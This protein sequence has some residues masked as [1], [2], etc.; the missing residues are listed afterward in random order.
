MSKATPDAIVSAF[1]RVAARAPSAPL[2]V[3]PGQSPVAVGA[4]DALARAAESTLG[5]LPSTDRV[6]GLAV[7]NGPA[8][9][10][11]FLAL[12][13]RGAIVL[14][15]DA[16]SP[17]SELRRVAAALGASALLTCPEAW[18][19]GRAG[20]SS[21]TLSPAPSA[22]YPPGTSVVKVT[23]GS[24]G[25]PRG[26]AVSS[27]ALAA[28]DAA[29]ASSMGLRAQER[30]IAAIP[31]AHSYG[32]SSV[33]LPALIRGSL[34]VVPA[35]QGPLSALAAAHETGATF[36]PTVPA[37]LQALLKMSKPPSWPATL[38]LVVSA[39]APL[40]P[41]TALGFRKTYGLPVHTFYGASECGGICYDREGD[42]GERGTVGEPVEGVRVTLDSSGHAAEG[43]VSV[44]S[45]ALALGYRGGGETKLFGNRFQ[46]SDVAS[47][48]GSELRILR[49][50]DSMINVRGRKVDPSEIE[51]VVSTLPGVEDVVA[52]GVPGP[53]AGDLLRVVI[54]CPVRRVAYADV[55]AHCRTH[56]P[57][58]KVP[59]SIIVVSEIP[60][61]SRGKVDRTALL[62]QESESRLDG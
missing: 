31:M 18:P 59:R 16:Q 58:H 28:D 36:L 56:L 17:A 55:L 52:L 39:G 33:A 13:R 61:T 4:L 48:A 14:L 9:L 53:G 41:A 46:T 12:R 49:R 50:M 7:P 51:R 6:I 26:V 22:P 10:A 30:I 20:F 40:L 42:A 44:A 45:P 43:V 21:E 32:F 47:W 1:G 24:T 54:A 23:S 25:Q 5:N 29:L 3:S 8:F 62:A 57:D 34:L 37:Y 15:L 27:D 19:T 35:P 60:R 11:G 38:R 2:L